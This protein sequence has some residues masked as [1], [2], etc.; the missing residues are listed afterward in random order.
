[1]TS[2][3][4]N[5]GQPPA[6]PSTPRGPAGPSGTPRGTPRLPS[7]GPSY[8][9]SEPLRLRAR[10]GVPPP[11]IRLGMSVPSVMDDGWWLAHLWAEDEDGLIEAR[12][13]APPAGP[14]PGAPLEV[15]G[16]ALA[17]ALSGLLAQAGGRALIRLR[18]PPAQ[19]ESRP[20][21]RPLLLWVAVAWDPVREA[22][23]RPNELAR[24][25]VRA[26]RAALVAA[27][28]PA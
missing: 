17:G 6:G 20:W 24:E 7:P 15:L 2:E 5:T 1:M 11:E 3:R 13:I 22:V 10:E 25:L 23:M 19:D 9:R 16:P 26:F 28:A 27:G 12:A 21:D 18:M 14:P 8:V 4:T